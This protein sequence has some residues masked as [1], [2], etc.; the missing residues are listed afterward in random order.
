MKII[1]L[2]DEPETIS[3]IQD[4]IINQCNNPEILIC[5]SFASF[6]DELSDLEDNKKNFII[7]DIRMIFNQEI[8]FSCFGKKVRINNELDSGFEYFNHCIKEQF[9][10]VKVVFFSSKPQTEAMQDAQRHQIDTDLIISKE[11]SLDLLNIIKGL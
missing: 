4:E 11:H 10:D 9:F 8:F 1:W 2:E 5:Q 7:I 3:V 6:S